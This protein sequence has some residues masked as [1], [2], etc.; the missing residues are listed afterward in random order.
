[1]PGNLVQINDSKELMWYVGDSQIDELIEW[2]NVHGLKE[3]PEEK[4]KILFRDGQPC[5]HNGCLNHRSHPCEGC[6]RI[7]GRGAITESPFK[8]L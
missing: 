6:G 1:M 8:P 7:A 4:P 3:K 5:K 2:L